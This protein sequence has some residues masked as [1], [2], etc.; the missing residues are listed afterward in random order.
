[1]KQKI[2]EIL[3]RN[4]KEAVDSSG[5]SVGVLFNFDKSVDEILAL[6]NH[7]RDGVFYATGVINGAKATLLK[8]QKRA[9]NNIFKSA[10]FAELGKLISD[11]NEFPSI[12]AR[13][14]FAIDPT[15][16][17]I[18]FKPFN[19]LPNVSNLS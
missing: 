15:S 18:I 3:D 10:I 1:M 13:G 14:Y 11:V 17:D 8:L 7:D 2:R 4:L 12:K 16:E 19:D 6:E 9:R 5:G